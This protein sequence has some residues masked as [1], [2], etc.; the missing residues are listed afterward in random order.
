[1]RVLTNEEIVRYASAAGATR[2]HKNV[3]NRYDFVPT[4]QAV[5]LLRDAGWNPVIAEQSRVNDIERDGVQKHMIRFCMDGLE[6]TTK[7]ERVD[8]VLYNSHDRGS[9]FKL[10][11]SIWRKVCGNGLMVA[12]DLFNFT[13]RH[14]NFDSKLFIQSAHEIV[15]NAGQIA[16]QVNDMRAIELTP[17]ER[18]VFAA[19]AHS[20]VY[21]EPDKAQ[22]KPERL[23]IERRYDDE[24]K[25][26]W[27]TFNVIQENLMKGGISYLKR[28]TNNNLRRNRTRKVKSIQKNIK[29]NKALWML[30]EKMA[31]LKKAA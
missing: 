31:E 23:L 5:D 12:S 7:Q 10:I 29:L 2:P 26:L 15:R 17:D 25:D 19:S 21:D 24:G 14:V 9:A 16:G 27:T 3:S 20:L 13:H 6:L 11:A 4:L 18:G 1:M 8:L 30:T 22:I 28:D